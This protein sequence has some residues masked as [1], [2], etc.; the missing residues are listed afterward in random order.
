MLPAHYELVHLE[1]VVSVVEEAERLA[2][3]GAEEG[4]LI[5]ASEQTDAR[6]RWGHQWY[7]PPGNLYCSLILRPDFPDASCG[8]LAYVTVLS[9][10]SALAGLLEPMTG[11]RYGWPTDIH[12]NDLKAGQI[13]L[14]T[15]PGA[16][17]PFQ[18]LTL[19]VMINVALHPPNP[20]PEMFNS[21]HASGSPEVR[22]EELLEGFGRQFLSW[23]NRWAEEGFEPIGRLWQ[24]RADGLG[25]PFRLRLADETLSGTFVEIDAAGRLVME[26]DEGGERRVSVGEYFGLEA[27]S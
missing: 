11:L 9:V 23:I 20:E 13:I 14:S 21:V 3:D 7:S 2:S 5:W 15:A 25:E 27:T 6:T 22:V 10:G 16:S 4:T 1:R 18:W 12:I 8:Q 26:S 19:S 17:D 24:Q